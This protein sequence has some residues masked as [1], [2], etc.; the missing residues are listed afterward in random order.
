M[1]KK[2]D[3]FW[4]SRDGNYRVDIWE[5]KPDYL[6]DGYDGQFFSGSIAIESAKLLGICPNK[7]QCKKYRLVEVEGK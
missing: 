5:K 7:N 2:K 1:P 4:A 6:V 3:V